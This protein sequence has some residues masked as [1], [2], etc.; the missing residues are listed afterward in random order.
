[1]KMSHSNMKNVV[2][3]LIGYIGDKKEWDDFSE[4]IHKNH[5]L[6]PVIYMRKN[7]FGEPAAHQIWNNA[8]GQ[9]EE[10]KNL[11]LE[12]YCEYEKGV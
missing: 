7:L 3:D 10:K 6:C 2:F 4:N 11:M 12:V 8:D 5:I 1:M 9:D